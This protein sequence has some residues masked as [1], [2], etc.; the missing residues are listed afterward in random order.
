M[1][2]D[3][4]SH[5]VKGELPG[6][7]HENGVLHMKAPIRRPSSAGMIERY[8]QLVVA[9]L[10]G[11]LQNV[12]GAIE[13]WDLYVQGIICAM[14]SRILRVYGG[15]TPSQ[16]FLGFE[17]RFDNMDLTVRD[18][19]IRD[20][21]LERVEEGIDGMEFVG[22]MSEIEERRG[23]ATEARLKEQDKWVERKEKREEREVK[24]GDLVLLRKH[25]LD[26][27]KG[28]KLEPRWDGP[29]KVKR[30]TGKGM[31]AELEDLIAGKMKGRYHLGD[32]KPYLQREEGKWGKGKEIWGVNGVLKELEGKWVPGQRELNL[33]DLM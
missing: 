28:R 5:F 3:N 27:Q 17:A 23:E 8:V 19:I 24:V 4:G 9:G 33:F 22:R 10:R 32:M 14:N 16:L 11:V 1:Y 2:T 15:Y 31:S 13:K 6:V 20:R 25:E 29:F 30:V 26:K 21:L 7:L 18:V 12:P